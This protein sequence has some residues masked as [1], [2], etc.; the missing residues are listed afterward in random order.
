MTEY[1]FDIYQDNLKSIF[2]KINKTLENINFVSNDK[3]DSVIT[4]AEANIKEAD[5]IVKYS[6]NFRSKTWKYN[7]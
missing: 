5:K 2:S 6:F 1:L 4:E 7:Q 3:A